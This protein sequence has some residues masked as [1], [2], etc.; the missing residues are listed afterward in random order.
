MACSSAAWRMSL[1]TAG[2]RQAP[3]VQGHCHFIATSGSSAS[4]GCLQ[5]LC[6]SAINHGGCMA[7]LYVA[8]CCLAQFCMAVLGMIAGICPYMDL[9]CTLHG[10]AKG[11]QAAMRL[12]S[13]MHTV[14]LRSSH[15]ISATAANIS[16]RDGLSDHDHTST[17]CRPQ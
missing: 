13:H 2:L 10:L 4:P 16:K 5:L 9:V 17:S 1:R 15:V 11:L 3:A 12:A 14:I 6:I 7:A 8:T